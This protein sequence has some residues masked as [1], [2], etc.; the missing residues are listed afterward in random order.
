[1]L[2]N[3]N[4]M[5]WHYRLQQ[6]KR[7][8][9]LTELAVYMA[10]MST[11]VIITLGGMSVVRNARVQRVVEEL[12]FY[13]NAI[14]DFVVKYGELPGNMSNERCLMFNEFKNF[15]QVLSSDN[16]DITTTLNT[17]PL[18]YVAMNNDNITEQVVAL[19]YGRFLKTSG[20]IE[21]VKF[22]LDKELETTNLKDGK[23]KHYLPKVGIGDEVYMHYTYNNTTN[24][25]NDGLIFTDIFDE[26]EKKFSNIGMNV[27]S[28]SDN[29][30]N[31]VILIF[32]TLGRYIDIEK[33]GAFSADFMEKIDKKIDDGRPRTGF[34]V[35][36]P[37][38]HDG[39]KDVAN[40]CDD[41]IDYFDGQDE[42]I[43][44][45]KYRKET[46]NKYGC[47]LAYISSIN[48]AEMLA[49]PKYFG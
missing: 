47:N 27:F 41:S 15:C 40:T 1:M 19:N 21:S 17:A 29:T 33:G 5:S 4:F 48:F 37:Q 14:S 20:I 18:S 46:D 42:R 6:C 26:T 28:F 24:R 30:D 13:E 39:Q 11:I 2:K 8:F 12:Y 32:S 31:A 22:G 45:V 35:G 10:V 36:L 23:I 16:Q 43:L 38:G 34:L 3:C 7:S 44:E 25:W 49:N 9:S